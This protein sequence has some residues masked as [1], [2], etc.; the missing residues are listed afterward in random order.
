MGSMSDITTLEAPPVDVVDL[1]DTLS[2]SDRCD[3]CGSQAYVGVLFEKG[4]LLFCG[5][6]FAK[7]ETL[8]RAVAV[9]V[10]DERY[11]LEPSFSAA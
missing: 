4:D 3:A 5:H 1:T 11:K 9:K 7:A 8:I 10:F 2:F 6:H